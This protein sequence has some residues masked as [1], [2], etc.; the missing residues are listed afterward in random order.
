MGHEDLLG[1]LDVFFWG[2]G[3]HGGQSGYDWVLRY[4]SELPS[5]PDRQLPL[6]LG[7]ERWRLGSSAMAP[8][9]I[10]VHSQ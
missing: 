9:E 3:R 1:E 5:S 6:T 4:P 2:P 10:T 8:S 7:Q